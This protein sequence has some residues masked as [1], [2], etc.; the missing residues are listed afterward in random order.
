MGTPV[1]LVSPDASI[2]GKDNQFGTQANPFVVSSDAS[3]TNYWNY[4]AAASGIVNTTTAVTI[5][6]AAGAGIRNYIK[7]LQLGSDTLGGATEVVV[8]DGAGGTVLWRAKLQ[9]TALIPTTINFDPPLRGTANLLMEVAAL[10]GVTG[11][12]YVD[13]Q[14]FTGA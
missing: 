14:G 8:R 11:G 13:A 10:T 3:K 1:T 5:K 2:P 4:A 6:T 9:T 12:I 7:S